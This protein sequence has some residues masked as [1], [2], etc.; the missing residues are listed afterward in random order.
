MTLEQLRIFVAVAEQ[1]HVTRAAGAL[2]L[3]QS[4][5][6][7]AIANLEARHAVQLFN[8]VGRRIELTEAGTLFLDEARA[9]L[10]RAEAAERLLADLSALRRGR[11]TVHASQTIIGYWLPE[12]LV[13]FRDRYPDVDVGVA[14]GNTAQVA[15]AVLDGAADLGLV[16]GEVDDPLLAQAT[17]PGDRMALV[18]AGGHPWHGRARLEADELPASPWVLRE[19]GSGTRSAFEEALRRQG[20]APERLPVVLELPSNEAVLSAVT[21][22]AGATVI[23]ELVAAGALAS[24]RLHRIAFPL[25]DRPFHLIHHRQRHMSHAAHAFCEQLRSPCPQKP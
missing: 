3:T 21:A 14:A 19:V 23:S 1:Q 6:S 16:E 10:A 5:V 7:A 18:V 12:R 8:R 11:V 24:G 13:A 22:G 20:V 15:Q 4:A 17:L 9:V 2:H 25:P